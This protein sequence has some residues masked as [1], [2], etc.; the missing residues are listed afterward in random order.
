MVVDYKFG[1]DNPD[2]RG[3]GFDGVILDEMPS[4]LPDMDRDY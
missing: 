3:L 2:A 4:C 1:V